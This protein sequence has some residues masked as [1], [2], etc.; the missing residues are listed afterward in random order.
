MKRLFLVLGFALIAINLGGCTTTRLVSPVASSVPMNADEAK[1]IQA[2]QNGAKE[3]S[4]IPKQV[5]P[6]V[7]ELT[8]I[9]RDHVIVVD[10]TYSKTEYSIAYKSS[11]NMRYNS[12]KNTIHKKYGKWVTALKRAIDQNLSL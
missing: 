6:N 8:L 9:V 2:I 11:N 5:S 12:S 1:V 7:I 3:K 10:V 4:W